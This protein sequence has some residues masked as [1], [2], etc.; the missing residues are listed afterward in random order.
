MFRKSSNR[1]GTD[2]DLLTVFFVT[3]NFIK[4][5]PKIKADGEHLY[6]KKN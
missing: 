1:L 2:T 4:F 3:L 5:E 6:F